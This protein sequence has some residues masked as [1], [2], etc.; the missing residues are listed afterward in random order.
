MTTKKLKA[1]VYTRKST[2]KGLEQDFNSLAAQR[3][4]AEAYITSQK[5]QGWVLVN[6]NYDDGGISGG[7]MERP[8]LQKLLDDVKRGRVD[9]IIVYKVD[10]LTRSLSDFARIIDLLDDAGASFVSVTQQFNTSNSMGR[11]TLNVLLS[12]AQ[13]EREVTAERIRDKILASK[14]KGMWM[15]GTVPLGYDNVDKKLVVNEEEA[16]LVNLIFKTYLKSTGIKQACHRINKLGCRT[17]ERKGLK[18]GNLKFWCGH[19]N[20]ILNNRLYIGEIKHK[21]K[22]YSGKH[23][24]IID[25]GTWQ[26]VRNKIQS[27]KN[28]VKSG[29]HFKNP[30]LLVGL[31][32]TDNGETLVPSHANKKGK[33]Y[34]YYITKSE[35]ID[36]QETR[37][38]AEQIEN[39]VIERIID[40]LEDPTL[41]EISAKSNMIEILKSGTPSEKRTEVQR[42]IKTVTL[43]PNQLKIRLDDKVLGQQE[44]ETDI[45]L[46][47]TLIVPV[48]FKEGK[49]SK[50]LVIPSGKHI[51]QTPDKKLIA[52]IAKAHLYAK[53]LHSGKY[54]TMKELSEKLGVNKSDLSKQIRL[55]YL[56]PEIITGI[57]EG[58]QPSIMNATQLRRL[59]TLPNDWDQQREILG[60]H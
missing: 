24:A 51:V 23:K 11:L 54:K 57:I 18:P 4:A 53:E 56:T 3:E 39:A 22:H 7:T 15:G 41:H 30:S 34:R 12:F 44:I 8:A 52:L 37:Y 2:D 46:E 58:R 60:F 40:R 6:D 21:E 35:K 20:Y 48:S 25:R 13:F 38:A 36:H 47:Q 28:N 19:I 49:K 5:S 27:S 10:R 42:L 55:A 14:R 43:S 26:K 29:I 59:S 17:K 9:I 32:K 50:K 1:A 33:R 16:E 31:L 45:D